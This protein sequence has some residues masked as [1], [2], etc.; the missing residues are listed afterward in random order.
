MNKTPRGI[1]FLEGHNLWMYTTCG[2]IQLVDVYN[3]WR[4]RTCRGTT[5]LEGKNFWWDRTSG[6]TELLEEENF[7]RDC[8]SVWTECLKDY[9]N[10]HTTKD[11]NP[12]EEVVIGCP[13][14][15]F[16]QAFCTYPPR[17]QVIITL[18]MDFTAPS[19]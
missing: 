11:C 17:Y 16:P 4:G 13:I 7:W 2:C 18:I 1:T 9:K 6:I 10:I 5:L 8:T 12:E 19:M 3:L 14:H 15:I